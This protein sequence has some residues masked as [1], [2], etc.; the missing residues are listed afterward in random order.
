MRI[1]NRVL[2]VAIAVTL[3][4]LCG[5][6]LWASSSDDAESECVSLALSDAVVA[7]GEAV[8]AAALG[9]YGYSPEDRLVNAQ[10]VVNLIE[11]VNGEHYDGD[12]DGTL[13]FS[14]GLLPHISAL[15][16]ELDGASGYFDDELTASG[17]SGLD[18]YVSMLRLAVAPMISV[19]EGGLSEQDV[20]DAYL[21]TLALLSTFQQDLQEIL[22]RWECEIWVRPG[23]SIQAAIDRAWPGALITV[24]P[25]VYR[26]T[27]DIST[28]LTLRG[29]GGTVVIEPVAGQIGLFVRIA[30][31]AGVR[32]E[33]FTVRRATVGIQVS[34]N[35]MCS[36]EGVE[37]SDCET[38]IQALERTQLSLSECTFRRNDTALRALGRS[39]VSVS[40][41]TIEGSQGDV[42][43][44]IVQELASVAIDWTDVIGGLGSGL[45]AL[46][47][48]Q[49]SI[50][51]SLLRFNDG[52]GIVVA[53]AATI[54]LDNVGCLGNDGYG[55]RTITDACPHESISPMPS[56][57]GEIACSRC[58]FGNLE[59]G[60]ENVLGATC[61]TDLECE[62]L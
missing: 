38:G 52:D 60:T 7:A 9:L 39:E 46:D 51:R 55:L 25:G 26:E 53:E 19:V 20:T 54:Y 3:V 33:D 59:E 47:E 4:A 50:Q 45:L 30:D 22:L 29:M 24:E 8:S 2:A 41:C 37:I 23:E 28:S 6:L 44:V 13:E 14:A 62:G 32:L 40:S 11:G 48:A 10:A 34:A 18:N 43:A 42:A 27:L 1:M 21:T 16:E 61:P 12:A 58:S 5:Q 17:R 36:L 35:T 49:V 56:F 57:T 31:E 15:N